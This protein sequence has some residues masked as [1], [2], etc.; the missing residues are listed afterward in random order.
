MSIGRFIVMIK[1]ARLNNP[2]LTQWFHQT[3]TRNFQRIINL[4]LYYAVLH[5]YINLNCIK[6]QDV[7]VF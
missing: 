3:Q 7:L 4:F 2:R 6:F 1:K 5:N